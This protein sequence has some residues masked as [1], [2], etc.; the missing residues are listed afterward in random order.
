[1][2]WLSLALA[3]V[4][5]PYILAALML[6]FL[7]DDALAAMPWGVLLGL[8]RLGPAFLMLCGLIAATLGFAGGCFA[9][10]LALRRLRF[11]PYLSSRWL[12]A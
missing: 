2:P 3:P 11:W 12:A 10:A 1:M 7:H 6:S 9:L 5:L 8:V 4:A